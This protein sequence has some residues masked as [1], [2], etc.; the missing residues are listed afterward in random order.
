MGKQIEE[1][2]EISEVL[3]RETY[4]LLLSGVCRG[5]VCLVVGFLS[6]FLLLCCFVL[7]CVCL[8]GRFFQL[9]LT[10]ALCTILPGFV[11]YSLM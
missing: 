4:R 8:V 11:Y 1:K 3:Q 10:C 7:V 6:V 5:V 2:N 9:P